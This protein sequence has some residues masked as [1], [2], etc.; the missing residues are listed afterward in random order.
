MNVL[1]IGNGGRE[2]AILL[3]LKK[4]KRIEK[5]Y[6]MKGNA[7]T[8]EI[9]ENVDVDY[10]DIAAVISYATAHPEIDYYVVTPDD[11]LAIGL[12][13]ALEGIG[14]RC[15]GPRKAAA[16]IEASKAF[17]KQLMKK[18]KIPTA[19]SETFS[20]YEQ[21]LAYVRKKGA[22]I[23]LKADGLA[24]GKGVLVCETLEQAEAGLKEI[25]LDKAFGSAGNKVVIEEFLR[26]LKYIPGE[27]VSVL[28]FTDGKAIVP[29]ITSCDH[30]RAHDG[31]KGLNT[32]GMGTFSPCPFWNKKLEKQVLKKIMIPT[33][34]A[35]NKEGRK[36]KGCL[37]FGLMRTDKGMKVV[38]YNSRFGDPETQVVLPMLKTDLLDI[39]EAVTEEKLSDIKIEWEDGACVCVVLASGGYPESYKKGKEITIGDTDGVTLVHAGTAIKDGKLVTNGGR[40]MG[41]VARGKD[42]EK[43]REKAYSAVKNI[44]WEN[45]QYRTDIGIKYREG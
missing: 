1:V 36:F 44:E 38:E 45:M 10:M 41:V 16:Q 19:E 23:V 33:V 24:L 32:G 22:P 9:A 30:K 11:P 37:Y 13:D 17:A 4:S 18:Y 29:M 39:F 35:M 42:V 40:V 7:G 14:K 20:D 25:M 34:K 31:D 28:A 6:C 2:H 21:A 5:L 3:A 12:V 27:E 26:G 43:A 8:A 15:F